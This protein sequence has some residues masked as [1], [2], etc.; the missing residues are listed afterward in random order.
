MIDAA[1]KV[2]AAC[3]DLLHR[4]ST[5]ANCD[6]KNALLHPN[7]LVRIHKKDFNDQVWGD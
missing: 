3:Q 7:F 2:Q 6:T 1:K 5:E 4:Y